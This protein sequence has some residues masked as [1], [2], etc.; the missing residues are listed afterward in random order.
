MP[1]AQVNGIEIFYEER[2]SGYPL[3]LSHEFAGSWESWKDQIRFFSRRYRVIA[4]NDRGYP[5]SSVPDDPAAYSEEQSVEDLRGLMDALGIAQAHIGG[6]SMG[7]AITLK[8]GIAYPERC[9]SLT[10]AGAGSGTTN[11]EQFLKEQNATATV[12]EERGSGAV[13]E[14]YTRG[15]ARVQLQSKDPLGFEEFAE[16]FAGHSAQGSARTMRGVQMQRRSI[17]EVQTEM[18]ACRVPALILTGDEDELCLE[19]AL[20]MKRTLPN[21]GLAILPKSGHPINLEEPALY[22]QLVLD[23]LTRVEQA[24][25][26]PR[27]EVST[28]MLPA[29]ARP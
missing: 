18:S 5:P 27:S 24:S 25:W 12:F 19:P 8:F 16:L 1:V 17:Y 21:A 4:Y 6:L 14:F 29:S 22:N 11:K 10:I 7:G 2:G 13:G 26:N 20:F 15:P 9:R 23:F 28:S 3:I